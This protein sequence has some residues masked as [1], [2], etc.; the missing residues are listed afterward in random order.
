MPVVFAPEANAQLAA[1]YRYIAATS[2]A[3]AERFRGPI[4]C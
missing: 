4:Q 2:P 3:A 1:L